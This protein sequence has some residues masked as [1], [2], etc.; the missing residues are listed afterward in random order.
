MKLLKTTLEL[1]GENEIAAFF[2]TLEK[3]EDIQEYLKN[4]KIVKL[5]SNPNLPTALDIAWFSLRSV[6]LVLKLVRYN[7]NWLD[8]SRWR[9]DVLRHLILN[10]E[11]IDPKT[12]AELRWSSHNQF[13]VIA[14]IISKDFSRVKED[15]V[16]CILLDCKEDFAAN[17]RITLKLVRLA[18]EANVRVP[19]THFED[20]VFVALA[21][22]PV[23]TQEV[24][25]ELSKNALKTAFAHV[26]SS[27][28]EWDIVL[29]RLK[30]AYE[31]LQSSG[32]YTEDY[33]T[34]AMTRLLCSAI[35]R[36]KLQEVLEFAPQL[37]ERYDKLKLWGSTDL[38]T[39]EVVRRVHKGTLTED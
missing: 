13:R 29:P 34:E 6:E 2:N 10:A 5:V 4:E 39:E 26:A 27:A 31:R 23:T 37:A 14:S 38:A 30:R 32:T 18:R 25:E 15:E 12:L 11:M 36:N 9:S 33:K 35:I 24:L 28:V 19:R 16:A 21:E 20:S 22:P 7:R 17:Y 3:E 8:V 1:L